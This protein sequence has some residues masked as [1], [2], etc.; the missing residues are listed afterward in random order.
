MKV[1][2]FK[3]NT[4]TET[5]H[6]YKAPIKVEAYYLLLEEC[7]GIKLTE[8]Q[9]KDVITNLCVGNPI[10]DLVDCDEVLP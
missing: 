3:P 1:F 10:Y 9:K 2:Q 7:L 6:V 8:F 4:S 5:D